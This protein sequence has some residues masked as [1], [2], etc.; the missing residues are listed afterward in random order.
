MNVFGRKVFQIRALVDIDSEGIIAG[1]LGGYIE[2]EGNLSQDGNAWVYGNAEVYGNAWVYG[3]AE[4]YGDARV[5]GNARLGAKLGYKKGWFIGGDDSGKFTDITNKTGSDFWRNQYVLGDYEIEE[6]IEDDDENREGKSA[7]D[8]QSIADVL[9]SIT[10]RLE[11]L[12]NE[13]KE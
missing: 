12:E 1:D 3:D 8:L 7:P 2:K 4:V 10:E 6:I 11:K 5:Y 13:I 9:T